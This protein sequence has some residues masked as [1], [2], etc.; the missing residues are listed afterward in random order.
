MSRS[1]SLVREKR[2][3]IVVAGDPA[4]GKT[5]LIRQYAD[6]KFI[7]QY[8]STVGFEISKIVY[9]DPVENEKISLLI[10]D[11]AGQPQ[12]GQIRP[13]FYQGANGVI[14]MFDLT[15]QPSLYHIKEWYNEMSNSIEG[16]R[17]S[18][19]LVGNKLDLQRKIINPICENKAKE[20]SLDYLEVSAKSGYNAKR[21]F[22][23]LAK[24]IK[25][26][27]ST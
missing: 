9:N 20:L 23:V 26:K 6:K 21:V 13:R 1:G 16:P 4:V 24:K 7:D 8:L 11:L 5:S 10:W 19:I 18:C 17:P 22:E 27:Y 12:F 2:Y 15:S 3:K 14:F 25:Q